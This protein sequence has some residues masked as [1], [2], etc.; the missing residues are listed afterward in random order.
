MLASVLNIPLE[1]PR[2]EEGPGYGA[3][4]LALVGVGAYE[5]VQAC[6]EALTAVKETVYPDPQLAERYEA[7][8][9]K[10]RKIYPSMKKLFQEVK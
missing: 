8:Y 4:M 1:L 6:A 7:Q 5:S 10:F 3:A 2:T 9:R